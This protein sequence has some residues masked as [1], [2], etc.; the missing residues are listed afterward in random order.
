MRQIDQQGAAGDEQPEQ[1]HVEAPVEQGRGQHHRTHRQRQRHR[2][3]NQRKR[4]G[5]QA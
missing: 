2:S 4:K 5:D 1:V 3:Q